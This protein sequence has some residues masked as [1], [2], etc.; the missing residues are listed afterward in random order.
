MTGFKPGTSP[1]PVRM[2][3]L[4]LSGTG[5]VSF[6]SVIFQGY[7]TSREK[8]DHLN[9]KPQAQK[10]G[11]SRL[12]YGKQAQ[13]KREHRL[14]TFESNTGQRSGSLHQPADSPAAFRPCEQVCNRIVS[15]N[16]AVSEDSS[17]G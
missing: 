10:A 12:A 15:H 14:H 16:C 8:R 1:P 3:I 9:E 5:M 13:G 7:R 11:P 4:S 17:K 2:P 6:R